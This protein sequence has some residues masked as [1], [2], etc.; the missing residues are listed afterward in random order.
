MLT[1]STLAPKYY[2]MCQL[3]KKTGE[4][5]S[6]TSTPLAVAGSISAFSTCFFHL[7]V[8]RFPGGAVADEMIGPVVL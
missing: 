6:G 1:V 3:Q 5:L 4:L 7:L 8:L 2:Y